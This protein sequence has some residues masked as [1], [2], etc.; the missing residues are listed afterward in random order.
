MNVGATNDD[1]RRLSTAVFTDVLPGVCILMSAA[2]SDT[3][4]VS[5]CPLTVRVDGTVSYF[6]AYSHSECFRNL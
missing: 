1:M 6:L 5:G 4:D 2:V 3:S